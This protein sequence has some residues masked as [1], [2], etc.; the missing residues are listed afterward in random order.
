[1]KSLVRLVYASQAMGAGMEH[2]VRIR[3]GALLVNKDLNVTGVLLASRGVF[4]QSLEGSGKDVNALYRKII[5]DPRHETC[6]LLYFDQIDV[7]F[8]PN[9]SMGLITDSRL[10]ERSAQFGLQLDQLFEVH[11]NASRCLELLYS[12]SEEAR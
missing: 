11:P 1:M 6:T 12:F 2:A 7:R 10:D 9:W 3:K 8:W 4:L 5:A